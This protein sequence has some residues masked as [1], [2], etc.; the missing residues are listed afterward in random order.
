MVGES[1]KNRYLINAPAGS[2][3]T[4]TIRNQLKKIHREFPQAR[5]L[6]ITFT[7]RATEELLKDIENPNIAV[8]TIHSYIN[9]L[10]SPFFAEKGTLDLYW[11]LYGYK[12]E[13]RI[14]NA[15]DDENITESNQKYIEKYG[16]LNPDLVRKNITAL[17]Y[18][19]TP[20]TSLYYGKLSHDDLLD[21]AY[22]LIQKY[23]VILKKISNKYN[24][25]YIDEYQDTSAYVLKIFNEAAKSNPDTMLYLLGDR[26]QQIY[27]NY[28][29]S[30]EKEFAEFDDS[31][32]L[33]I[34]Y[35]SCRE[36]V[37]ILNEI[38]NDVSFNQN[39]AN[40]NIDLKPDILPRIIITTT[41]QETIKQIQ[42]DTPKILSLY[43][44]NKEKYEEI[45][46]L[47]LYQC[48]SK[49]ESYSFGKK[50]SSSDVLSDLSNENPDPLMTFLIFIDK[51][52][53]TYTNE[54][55][56][57]VIS[58]CKNKKKYF[59]SEV[60]KI[61]K[62]NDKKR[63]K[64]RLDKIRELYDDNTCTIRALFDKLKELDII[65]ND[66]L[67]SIL[68]N[69]EY[70]DVINVVFD[71]VKKLVSFLCDPSISTQHGVKGESHESVVFIAND[72]KGTP[73]V[74]MTSFFK[75]WS[76]VDFSLPEF[77]NMYFSYIRMIAEVEKSIG[78]K[79]T[80]LTKATHNDNETNKNL[81]RDFSHK[82]LETYCD[83]NIFSA[84]CKPAFESYLN[85]PILKNV[86]NI[87]NKSNLE[88]ILTAYKLFYVG[89]SRARKNLY[90]VIDAGK[91]DSFKDSFISKARKTGFTIEDKT[92]V[93]LD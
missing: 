21:F 14:T 53:R 35:R 89:C 12:I 27:H 19:E 88:G 11:E 4:T 39:L 70:N 77:E 82:A 37:S 30:F 2:G 79:T 63:L 93:S 33:D 87:F 47:N 38:Y 52:I 84:I 13:E 5:I 55:Y 71:E 1:I 23:P 92:I 67:N 32:K 15:L 75:L 78:M 81:L 25:I 64:E 90:V 18:G 54:N 46:A 91:I 76:T 6:C 41:P 28:D 62:H 66:F 83:N 80:E 69:S 26:M 16:D 57:S 56:G 40:T 20:F 86:K 61:Q 31:K 74:R 51:I 42:N 45:G 65:N 24:Y 22:K 49:M 7:N 10:V 50:F 8:S 3:K 48:Y 44:M 85:N 58:L 68:E 29:G 9:T 72:S 36:I 73:N 43:L 60:F 34:N 17:S 59:N